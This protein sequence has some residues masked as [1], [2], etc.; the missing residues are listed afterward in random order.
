M[1]SCLFC[2][3]FSPHLQQI[4]QPGRQQLRACGPQNSS[5][6]TP[7]AA[8]YACKSDAGVT[9]VKKARLYFTSPWV[10]PLVPWKRPQAGLKWSRKHGGRVDKSRRRRAKPARGRLD[11]S[12]TLKADSRQTKKQKKSKKKKSICQAAT[13]TT[14]GAHVHIVIAV[15]AIDCGGAVQVG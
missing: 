6:E 3:L 7:P 4:W 9:L 11:A 5:T 13:M 15:S 2:F 8:G 12:E 10:C 1:Q 14:M